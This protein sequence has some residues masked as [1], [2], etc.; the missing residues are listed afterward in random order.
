MIEL[1]YFAWLRERIGADR[2][3]ISTDA[4][5]IVD[6]IAELRGKSDAHDLVFSDLYPLCA[7]RLIRN[8]SIWIIPFRARARLPSSHR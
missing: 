2:E 1:R 8:W 4:A 3:M 5:T 6:L 7:R